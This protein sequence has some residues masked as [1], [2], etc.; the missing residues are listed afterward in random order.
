MEARAIE[1]RRNAKQRAYL[2][3]W[4]LALSPTV[5]WA[6]GHSSWAVATQEAG[7]P[8]SILVWLVPVILVGGLLLLLLRQGQGQSADANQ[9][10]A[11]T[12]SK[13][14]RVAMDR[15]STTF[16]D[17]AGVDEAKAEMQ[18][19][20]EFLKF[21]A[22]FRS[23]GARVPKGLLL[24][25][26]P[27]TGKT[28]LAR[29]VAGEA[30]VPFFSI[31]ASEFVELFVGVGASRVRDLF[32]QAKEAAPCIVFIDEIDAVGRQRG[33]G[34]G[35][36]HEEREQTLNQILVEMDGFDRNDN[37]I[38]IAATNRADVLDPALTRPGRFDRRV[39][40]DLP[41]VRGRLAILQVHARGKP[42][43]PSANLD[44]IARETPGFS[45][46]DLENLINEAAILSARRG[47]V[48]IEQAELE[49]AIERVMAGPQRKSRLLGEQ[50]RR[51]TAY[52]EA[53]HTLVAYLLPNADPVHK[54]S[55][56]A[57]GASGGQTWLLP[58]EDRQL[59]TKSQLVD[60]LAF[61]LGGLAAEELV[62]GE[63]TTGSSHDL[64]QATKVARRMVAEFGMSD[65]VGPAAFGTGAGVEEP[66]GG[67][68][69]GESHQYGSRLADEIDAETRRLVAEAHE[70]A[71]ALLRENAS[72]LNS[73]AEELLSK[74]TLRA[75]DLVNLLGPRSGRA[76]PQS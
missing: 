76:V 69:A 34:I 67:S 66:M 64:A 16:V 63:P 36:G 62:F 9:T 8:M 4:L 7:G 33:L 3:C 11:F 32:A 52:H 18:E 55:I 73:L 75:E 41:D 59:W 2:A 72:K 54:V 35:G 25:G 23:L 50:E 65:V 1:R 15:P 49:E 22:K 20:V 68:A 6:A 61:A 39:V 57:R 28:L 46:A 29:A 31:S 58:A 45:G 27:G 44:L 48:R 56:V 53:G 47:Q 51:I 13:A 30:G 71:R 38:V 17:V 60:S 70:R 42:L 24:V 40:L 21:P 37:V 14:R 19:V 74:E 12:R 5:A 43:A 26:H 10:M